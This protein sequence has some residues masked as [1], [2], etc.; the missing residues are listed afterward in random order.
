MREPAVAKHLT[1]Q[2]VPIRMH[3][4]VR[5]QA[6]RVIRPIPQP[7]ARQTTDF[8]LELSSISQLASYPIGMIAAVD[9]KP[10]GLEATDKKRTAR[11][12]PD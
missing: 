8:F 7:I 10:P 9:R 2:R 6:F 1:D 12:P 5:E 4:P 11:R 3:A